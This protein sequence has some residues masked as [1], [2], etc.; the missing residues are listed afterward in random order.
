MSVLDHRPLYVEPDELQ[1]LPTNALQK[2]QKIF[3]L[4]SK[5]GI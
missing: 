4:P 1:T 2:R 5:R 3:K